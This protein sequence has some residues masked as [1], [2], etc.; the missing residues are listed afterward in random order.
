MD[1]IFEVLKIGW[2]EMYQ[3]EEVKQRHR[4][5]CAAISPDLMHNSEGWTCFICGVYVS[6]YRWLVPTRAPERILVFV[7]AISRL[8]FP[9]QSVR[10]ACRVPL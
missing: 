4:D 8:S 1:I 6:L 9:R 3:E 2:Y 7:C 5:L 10:L